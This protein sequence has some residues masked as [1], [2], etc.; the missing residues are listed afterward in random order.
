MLT[1]K[2]VGRK[3]VYYPRESGLRQRHPMD[4]FSLELE[5][6]HALPALFVRFCR[7]GE[8]RNFM[9]SKLVIVLLAVFSLAVFAMGTAYSQ[10][11]IV[12]QKRVYKAPPGENFGYIPPP[13]DLSHITP[14]THLLG[15]A[16]S[17]WDWRTMGGVTSVKNQNPY[18]TC[19]CFAACG[20]LE[21]KVLI[22]ESVTADYSE[23]NIQACNPTSYHD[24][25]AGGNAWISNNY[26]S[27]SG[28]VN[29]TCDPYPGGCPAP[30]CI[31]PSCAFFKQVR[32]WKLIPNDVTA[33]KNAVQGYG[34]VYTSMYASFSGFG[35][36]DG[37][38]CITY[39]G[40]EATNHAVL[41][42]GWDDDMCSGN[43]AWIVKNSWGSS[44]GD[45]GYFYI[46]YGSA[47]IGQ[48]STVITRYVNYDSDETIYYFD[49]W[50]WWTS[51]GYG[52]GN[53]WGLMELT[54]SGDNEYLKKVS[55]SATA[56]GCS[57]T[58]NVYDDFSSGSVSN[59]LS[60]PVSGTLSEAGYYTVDLPSPLS[61]SSGDPVYVEV[62]FN[63]GS[64][65]YPVPYDD[66]G[67]METNKSF[68]SND[69]VSYTALDN[70][71]YAMGDISI[72][73]VVEVI[74]PTAMPLLNPV[75]LTIFALVLVL[76]AAFI[77]RKRAAVKA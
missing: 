12:A 61:L 71:N 41:I 48:N 29:E 55:F 54:P 7:S 9:K 3:E 23:L 68:I 57:Y 4:F 73:G 28:S 1:E 42:V 8:R 30:T 33:I 35:T 72:R 22:N 38:Y 67:A 49:E 37:S 25:N 74:E 26:L 24:C 39:S 21:S 69:G 60:G 17:S 65:G 59:L 64:Y 53:D 36:Y 63:T 40:T 5:L 70:G 27:L 34:P 66:T 2:V 45:N 15:A 62:E 47:S 14:T 6:L 43:G 10:E 44:W 50:G 75:V 51:A 11:P 13:M 76:S 52:D 16:A 58:I 31:N 77:I 56:S 46:Q 20:D 19:W 18:G 32:E